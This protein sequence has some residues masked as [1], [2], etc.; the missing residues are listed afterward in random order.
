MTA[1]FHAKDLWEACGHDDFRGFYLIDC[2]CEYN[3]LRRDSP[4]L[5]PSE[6]L[7][8]LR[9]YNDWYGERF[10]WTHTIQQPGTHD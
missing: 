6:A 1:P 10:S 9:S 4:E 5:S 2:A 8:R 3:K 7:S